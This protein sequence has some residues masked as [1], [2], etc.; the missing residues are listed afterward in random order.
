MLWIDDDRSC[1]IVDIILG[2]FTRVDR[3]RCGFLIRSI[4]LYPYRRPAYSHG[5][6]LGIDVEVGVISDWLEDTCPHL[7]TIEV[8]TRRTASSWDTSVSESDLGTRTQTDDRVVWHVER[9]E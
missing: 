7:T 8:G 2:K 1:I 9:G 3:E 6:L 4:S 5:C